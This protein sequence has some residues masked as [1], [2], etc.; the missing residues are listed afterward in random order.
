MNLNAYLS[1]NFLTHVYFSLNVKVFSKFKTSIILFLLVMF[2]FVANAQLEQNFSDNLS[3]KGIVI[4]GNHS[5]SLKNQEI[6]F[7]T[8]LISS[9]M[10]LPEEKSV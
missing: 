1:L 2:S 9:E 5:L 8:I 4:E 6:L 7:H 3:S 10:K